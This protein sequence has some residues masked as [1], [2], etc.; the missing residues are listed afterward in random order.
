MDAKL[1][2]AITALDAYPI[3]SVY[4][5]YVSTSPASLFGGTWTPI[6]GVF[7]Y[8]NAGTATGGSNDAIV[9]EH[10]HTATAANAGSHTHGA[11]TNSAGAHSHTIGAD[12]DAQ[13]KEN[14]GTSSVHRAGATGAHRYPGTS[15]AGSHSHS[16]TVN[17]AGDHTHTITVASAGSS[18]TG[19][20]MPAYQ[21]LYAWRRTA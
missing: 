13:F 17:S 6:T 4:I 3:G 12:D 5:S 11:S 10:T 20:N 8:F 16:V 19:K 9:V 1:E 14:S 15:S 2:G 21:T 7:P 18:G